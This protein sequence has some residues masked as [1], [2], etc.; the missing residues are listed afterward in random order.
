VLF[1]AGSRLEAGVG[2]FA[3]RYGEWYASAE[4]R[5]ARD[6]LCVR[7]EAAPSLATGR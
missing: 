5:L 3:L 2:V 1:A 7:I 4:D 6:D